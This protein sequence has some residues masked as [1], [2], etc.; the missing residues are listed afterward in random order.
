MS[1]VK[2]AAL[3][4]VSSADLSVAV[5]TQQVSNY[6]VARYRAARRRFDRFTVVSAMNDADFKEFLAADGSGMETIELFAGRAAYRK[7]VANGRLWDDTNSVLSN[8][9]PDIVA[10]AGWS[11][12]ESLAAIVWAHQHGVPAVLMSE[13]QQHDAPRTAVR[14]YMKSRI[15]RACDAALV[16]GR[17]HG[18]YVRELGLSPERI[19]YGYDAVDN[20]HFVDGADKAQASGAELRRTLG[21]PDRYFLASG[22][23]IAKKNFVRLVQA[24]GEV[25]AETASPHHLVILGDGPERATI[26][27]AIRRA[28]LSGAALTRRIH[29]LGFQPYE[30]L[31][32]YYG[33]A[34]AFV[35]ISLT[36]QWGLVINE[37]SASGLPLVVSR[38]C[39]A[40]DEL[41]E[42]GGN[43]FLVDPTDLV[44]IC[45]ALKAILSARA[46]ERSAMGRRSREIVA[47]W[48]PERFADGLANAVKSALAA[49]SGVLA[50]W[51]ALMLRGL[52]RLYVTAVS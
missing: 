5:L 44:S 20:Q 39:G 9:N 24:F 43:G 49:P 25:L 18:D 42:N 34:E 16:G 46:E 23:L 14:E 1:I 28:G 36:E 2:N 41:V 4:S 38:P 15:V 47:Q 40:A 11:V 19:F 31:P 33:L 17:V 52:S 51:D 6:H 29:L 26:V 30:K 21:L 45:D 35:H 12:P 7:A 22:R 37:A 32:V 27:E 10:V 13:S 48:G 3:S 8:I 50:A